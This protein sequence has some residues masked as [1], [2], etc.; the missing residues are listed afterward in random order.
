M[1][2]AKLADIPEI[3]AFLKRHIETSMFPLSNLRAHGLD[4]AEP[5]AMSIWID[6]AAGGL[7]AVTRE[8]MILPQLPG[9]DDWKRLKPL[10]SDRPLI[11]CIGETAQVRS[12]LKI[13]GLH[14]RPTNS[15]S[16]EPLMSLELD[17]LQIDA[18][19]G[20]LVPLDAVPSDV[21]YAWRAAYHVEVL[22]TPEESSWDIG[23]KDI[24]NYIAAD[25]H[26]ALLINGE[27]VAMTGFNAVCDDVVQIGGV[28]TPPENRKRGFAGAA[29]GQHLQEVRDQGKTR[30]L[31]FAASETAA[32]VYERLGF[33]LVGA[34]SLCLFSA[35]E[36]VR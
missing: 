3:E 35:P 13:C 22:G 10:L 24:G 2:R 30:A 34:Y 23:K 15:N 20:E 28:Y 14:D 31:L 25:S 5:R 19:R 16:D 9:F 1:R 26:R 32:G 12:L 4:G 6:D 8:G 36:V 11:G 17:E 7:L 27:P 18:G 29:I 33:G 21:T